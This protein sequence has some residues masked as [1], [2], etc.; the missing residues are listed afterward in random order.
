VAPAWTSRGQ[1]VALK[2]TYR[3]PEAEHE[4]DALH[5]WAGHGAVLLHEAEPAVDETTAALLLERCDGPTLA[6]RGEDVVAQVRR[7]LRNS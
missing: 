1:T 3:H 5:A 2:V 6:Q 7:Q 4:A